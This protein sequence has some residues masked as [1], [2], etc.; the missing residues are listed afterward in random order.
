MQRKAVS[1]QTEMS[2]PPVPAR[3]RRSAQRSPGD[4]SAD[5]HSRR[6]SGPRSLTGCVLHRTS[7]CRS[8]PSFAARPSPGDRSAERHGGTLHG[9]ARRF[10]QV[11]RSMSRRHPALH[12]TAVP[13]GPFLPT[14]KEVCFMALPGPVLRICA[15]DRAGA[16]CAAGPPRAARRC[17]AVRV[18]ALA[19]P[20]VLAV[21]GRSAWPTH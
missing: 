5:G 17:A 6:R 18:V 4:R 2:R 21:P 14:A 10:A 7:R 9:L 13:R 8:T 3:W 15:A 11:S 19:S 16:R 20:M 12:R 1:Q